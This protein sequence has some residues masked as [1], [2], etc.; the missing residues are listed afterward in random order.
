MN[1]TRSLFSPVSSHTGVLKRARVVGVGSAIFF[2]PLWIP[3]EPIFRGGTPRCH[4]I[5]FGQCSPS[6]SL[7]QQTAPGR[8]TL[9][10][11]GRGCGDS[12]SP[13]FPFHWRWVGDSPESTAVI[14]GNQRSRRR[15]A[16]A[17]LFFRVVGI[18]RGQSMRLTLG[19]VMGARRAGFFFPLRP[20]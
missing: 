19:T 8:P 6:F 18:F 13:F 11:R 3:R 14:C 1:T 2:F 12:V 10:N 7:L 5:G 16:F 15:S 17:F 20:Y 9:I 4:H